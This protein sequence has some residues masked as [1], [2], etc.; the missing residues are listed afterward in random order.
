LACARVAA[1][2]TLSTLQLEPSKRLAAVGGWADPQ[3]Q[4]LTMLTYD[5]TGWSP[6]S[7]L[8]YANYVTS[9]TFADSN[10]G[11]AVTDGDTQAEPLTLSYANGSWASTPNGL[12][13]RSLKDVHLIDENLGFAVGWPSAA[14]PVAP[15]FKYENG[16]WSELS[17]SA[18]ANTPLFGVSGALAP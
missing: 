16:T 7:G 12:P 4:Q 6:V 14:A 1:W 11:L 5:G 13:P 10:F 9:I 2:N 15:V 17:V 3:S 18:P 8:P